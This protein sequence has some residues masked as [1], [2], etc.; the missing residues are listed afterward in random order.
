[1]AVPL[2]EEERCARGRRREEIEEALAR[3]DQEDVVVLACEVRSATWGRSDDVRRCGG[4]GRLLLVR[5]PATRDTVHA[6]RGGTTMSEPKTRT[7]GAV[8]YEDFELL[9]LYGPLEMFGSIGAG[10]GIVTVAEKT[11][12]VASFQGPKT[13]A[14]F[15][16]ASAP[17]LDLILLPGGFG[18]IPQLE[19][20]A[21]L[22]FLRRRAAAAEVTMSVCSGSAILAKAGLLDG[23]RATS[24]KQFFDLARA[25][26][27]AVKWVEQARWVEDGPFA[28]SSGVSAGTDMALAV[29][30]KLY[31]K[32]M[33][34]EIAESTEYEWQ[35]DST[36]DPFVR[37][38]NKGDAGEVL[39]RMGRE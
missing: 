32:E 26:G 39:R 22:D 21:M 36:R 4:F 11:G 29:I 20:S 19:N 16:F 24:N 13:V 17:K 35:Q 38:L 5:E 15:D 2:A 34:Q 33:A 7:L 9:D 8:L 28:T 37:F 27:A 1:M 23:R 10:L 30:A 6:E 14:E 12:P 18:T 31:G 25:Q 3:I